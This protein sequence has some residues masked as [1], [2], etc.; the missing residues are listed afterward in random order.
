M[1]IHEQTV[2]L[3]TG[4]RHLAEGRYQEALNQLRPLR[5]SERLGSQARLLC[6]RLFSEMGQVD[7]AVSELERL[8][9]ETPDIAGAANY[10][11]A[12]L[13]TGV[14]PV[15]AGAYQQ[16][17]E[18]LLARTAEALFLRALTVSNPED[19]IRHLSQAL[20]LDP[21]H[22]PSRKARALAYHALKDH[23]SMLR[24][25]EVLIALRPQDAVGYALRAIGQRETGQFEEA[26]KNHN[27]AL[28]LCNINTELPELHNQRRKTYLH[29]GK[30]RA[31]LADARRCAELVPNQLIYGFHVF[32]A[33]VSL[34]D[35]EA[36]EQH[37]QRLVGT[38]STEQITM[39]IWARRFVVDMMG[40]GQ[41]LDIPLEHTAKRAFSSV[42]ETIT[43]YR[44]LQNKATRLLPRAYGQISWS[45][46][47]KRLAY[48][49]SDLHMGQSEM[50][51]TAAP[52]LSKSRG[53]EVL[54]LE[55]GATRL[56]V[57]FGRDPAWSPDGRY[58]AFVRDRDK[59]IRGHQEEVWIIPGAGGESRRIAWGAQA[60][61]AQDA[62]R[63]FFHSR[64][65]K[66]LYTIR[67]DDPAA[68][69]V[70]IMCCPS[71]W[72][73]LSPDEKHLAYAIGR[74]LR[75][76]D[77]TS[78]AVVNQW[79]APVPTNSMIIHWSPEGREL[80]LGGSPDSVLGLWIFDRA[81][82]SA[83]QVLDAPAQAL[84]WSPDGSQLG[85]SM[86]DPFEEIWLAERDPRVP[87]HQALAP[88]LTRRE[89][90]RH[91]VETDPLDV[92]KCA[93]RLV[94]LGTELYRAGE[95]E[96]ALETSARIE[97]LQPDMGDAVPSA[98][99]RTLRAL[100]LYQLG[101]QDQAR[102]ALAQ[103]P[104]KPKG[105][106]TAH[107]EFG[108]G[109]PTCLE[110][111]VN[112]SHLEWAID[113]GADNLTLFIVS[114]RPSRT[115][116]SRDLWITTRAS[117]DDAWGQPEN[118]GSAVNTRACETG[119]SISTDGLV[120]HFS[121]GEWF[122]KSQ[123]PPRPDGY[124]D[125]DIW[126]TTRASYTEDWSSP[127][128]LGPPINSPIYEGEPDISADG[129]SLYFA[130]G[131]GRTGEIGGV[132][133]WVTTRASVNDQWREPENLGPRVNSSYT[134]WSPNI[135]TDGLMLL[136]MSNRP[137]HGSESDNYD[138]WVTTRQTVLDNWSEPVKLGAQINGPHIEGGPSLSADGSTLFFHSTRPGGPGFVNLWQADIAHMSPAHGEAVTQPR[139]SQPVAYWP[140]DETEGAIAR[141]RLGHEQA[142]LNGNPIWHPIGGIQNGAL[143]MDGV[144][145]CVIP[146]F[147]LNPAQGSF[148]VFAW[149]KGSAPRGVIMSQADGSGWGSN[150]LRLAP[151]QG[152]LM[153]ELGDPQA[154]LISNQAIAHGLWHHIGLVWDGSYRYLYVDGVQTA[155]DHASLTMIPSDGSLYWGA[156]KTLDPATAW[157]GLI[158]E[159]RV[160]AY[161]LSQAEVKELHDRTAFRTGVS[162]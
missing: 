56:L 54:D 76:V 93:E 30:H 18:A 122:E 155:S 81:H 102:T 99:S 35:Y 150:W 64:I 161:A 83:Q 53:I 66:M 112:S 121:D 106:R 133:L 6:A 73:A 57:G 4:Q 22:C 2:A 79:T 77:L 98:R 117:T 69:P 34:G 11:L 40:T 72:P 50:S 110:S 85:I 141:N 137:D 94:W 58:L 142:A 116:R 7:E 60:M 14:D 125:G 15:R 153:S 105:V 82:G 26:I 52:A 59:R 46:D 32:T 89:F 86:R 158:D 144:D 151:A 10:L 135:S 61:W 162:P 97:S 152:T 138:I 78:N 12:T 48:G 67:I 120:L 41:S 118:L 157:P 104:A 91:L 100:A 42:S 126:M 156:G 23:S 71:P 49:R 65:D 143:Q 145:D 84:H 124:G 21:G 129:L 113:I 149:I 119:P 44:R 131:P 27:H 62:K 87:T 101:R 109:I 107:R 20:E 9:S 128:N 28:G 45:P 147:I 115:G 5:E 47:G 88:A 74:Q 16:R 33:L 43:H 108:L 3:D 63:I 123:F 114:D 70:P 38:D 24:D 29:M 127:L 36:A 1:R 31:A 92:N 111:P 80:S 146:P 25:V 134:D 140:M 139:E 17:A 39:A 75:V 68:Q 132:D 136:F 103:Q 55:S 19:I 154:P 148:S 90:L 95:Y 160:Y 51:A 8:L 130:S 159:V 13:Y 37:F 96:E